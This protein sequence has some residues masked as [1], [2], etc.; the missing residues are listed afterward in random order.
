[1]N[2]FKYGCVVAGENYCRRP[3]LQRQLGELVKSGQNVVVQGPRRMGKTSLVVETVNSLRGIALLYVDL[4]SVKSVGDFCRKVVAATA[5]CGK[6]SFLE[7]TAE[8]V[9]SL[10]P[11]FT[12]DRDT[13]APT[14][15]VDLKAARNVESVE[16][17]MDMI[18]SHSAAKRFCVVFDE[19][20]DVLDIPEADA[21]L[22]SLRSKIQFLPDTPFIFLGSVRN[23]MR[24]IF[25]SPRSPFFKSAIS[26][27]VER[28]EESAMTDFLI[29]RFR[30]GNRSIDRETVGKILATADYISGD[31]QELCETTWLVTGDGHRISA[32]DVAK[33]LEAVFARESRAFISTF[34]KLTAV[35]ASVLKGLADPD[36]CKVFSGEFLETYGIR[37]VGSVSKALKRL[38]RDEI[39]YEFNGEYLFENPFF[40]EWVRRR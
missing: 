11:V 40:R 25:D 6:R 2:P 14:I 3:E 19:F 10:R 8:L 33:G 27:G 22:A 39:I 29:G 12:V 15:S 37:N 7:R 30:A 17:V 38:I 31:I 36:H 16:E 9:K 26:F 18:A 21:V 20:Q 23:R 28:I 24:D 1:M 5:K 13:G 32:G 34:G 35:Q 4:F